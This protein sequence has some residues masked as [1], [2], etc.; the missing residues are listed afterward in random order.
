MQ[1]LGDINHRSATDETRAQGHCVG[2]HY[3]GTSQG[4]TTVRSTMAGI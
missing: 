2:V 4:R 3:L 1:V